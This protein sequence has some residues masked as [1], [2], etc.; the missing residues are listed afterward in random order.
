MQHSIELKVKSIEH[1][2]GEKH[3]VDKLSRGGR[4][5]ECYHLHDVDQYPVTDKPGQ[6]V[7]QI[8]A[9]RIKPG[10]IKSSLFFS[11]TSLGRLIS[12]YIFSHCC[13]MLCKIKV[14]Y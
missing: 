10:N 7:H 9:D 8:E 4:V 13:K 5:A 6:Y 2:E 12:T 1:L 3:L 14:F 11:L